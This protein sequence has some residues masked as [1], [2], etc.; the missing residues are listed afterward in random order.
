MHSQSVGHSDPVPIPS[1]CR[2]GHSLY[3]TSRNNT[4]SILLH[5]SR[6]DL[7]LLPSFLPQSAYGTRSS[8]QPA[9]SM[10]PPEYVQIVGQAQPACVTAPLPVV[11]L[12]GDVLAEYVQF[13]KEA[14][15]AAAPPL[16]G[17]KWLEGDVL[18][19]Y[20]Q[21]LKEAEEAAAPPLPGVKW[22]EGDVLANFLQFLGQDE[23]VVHYGSDNSSSGSND[24]DSMC[25]DEDDDEEE[26]AYLLRHITSLPAFMARA[27]AATSV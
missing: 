17:V 9:G 4:S 26:M 11:W 7:A 23:Q 12:E 19:E 27:A 24:G 22:L 16:P 21:F 20:V 5:Q 15:E 13:L 1:Y 25:E 3:I 8:D 10:A 14:E 6:Q 2:I 18:A